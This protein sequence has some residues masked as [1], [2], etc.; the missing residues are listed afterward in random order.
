MMLKVKHIHKSYGKQT[1]L[2]D[3]S[4][5][6]E[7][8]TI[9]GLVGENGAGKST[10]INIIA[11]LL[12]PDKGSVVL[13]NI[14]FRKN[15]KQFRQSVGYIP[16]E[17][18]IWDHFTVR[19]NML[20]FEKLSSVNKTEEQLKQLCL[21]MA[22]DRWEDRADTLSG[23]QKRKL[24]MAIS[25]I[26]DPKLL[27]L[28]EP[29]VGIDMKSKAEIVKF[30]KDRVYEEEMIALYTSHDMAEIEELCDHI[31]CIGD[32]PFYHNLLKDSDKTVVRF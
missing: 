10:L 28:D 19:E 30:I 31:I 2:K 16:Q 22:L 20:F 4:F 14:D 32:D 18:S 3:I 24:N 26:H 7:S 17:I 6:I 15:E 1:V 27:L 25:L 8:G 29:T 11:S 12:K 23:G 9:V 13:G 5:A 21:D